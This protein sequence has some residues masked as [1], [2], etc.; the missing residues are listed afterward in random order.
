MIVQGKHL[1]NIFKDVKE[2]YNEKKASL[3]ADH[4]ARVR[5]RSAQLTSQ[6]RDREDTRSEASSRHSKSSRRSHRHRKHRDGDKSSRPP[7]TV[8]N[9]SQIDEE[10]SVVSSSRRSRK[11]ASHRGDGSPGEDGGKYKSPYLENAAPSKISLVR[12]HTDFPTPL[13]FGPTETQLTR[14]TVPPSY[15][16]YDAP[17]RNSFPELPPRGE[18]IDMNLAYGPIPHHTSLADP[19][20]VDPEQVAQTMSKLDK[21]LLEAHCVQHTASAMMSNLQAN[22]EAM[23]AVALTLAELSSLLTKMSPSIIATLKASSPAIFA[24]LASPQFLIAGGVA[25]GVT[26]V[27]FGGFKIIKKIQAGVETKRISD[28]LEEPLVFGPRILNPRELEFNPDIELSSIDSW[29]RGI[30]EAEAEAGSTGTSVDGEFITPAA[31]KQNQERILDKSR[32]GR[33][34][35]AGSVV[36]GRSR[37]TVKTVASESTVRSKHPP[38]PRSSVSK[39][40]ASE[41]G[42]SRSRRSDKSRRKEPL[43]IE[44]AK[45][46]SS[47]SGLMVLFKKGKKDKGDRG[48]VLSLRP[49]TI[50]I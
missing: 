36:S 6:A 7:L 48:S 49:K 26:V 18:H 19:D 37:R 11:S 46:S 33:I 10:G 20:E 34:T 50:E 21:L 47:P 35:E 39:V 32:D 41:A 16:T 27:M 5:S 31:A 38:A 3:Q 23:A 8:H 1:I 9:L 29:R 40:A 12:R 44:P 25:L 43:M 14:S 22:P 45:K 4:Q 30:A 15:H 28:R 2:A 17:R 24:L 13:E 42:T